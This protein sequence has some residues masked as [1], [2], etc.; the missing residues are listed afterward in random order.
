[1]P[2]SEDSSGKTP[3]VEAALSQLSRAVEPMGLKQ[4]IVKANPAVGRR[5][6][7]R[8]TASGQWIAKAEPGLEADLLIQ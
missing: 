7:S 3:Q 6:P 8:V 2:G 5:E 4:V 1:M